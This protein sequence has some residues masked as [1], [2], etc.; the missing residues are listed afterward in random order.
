MMSKIYF[1]DFF[2]EL[3]TLAP[4]PE[5]GLEGFVAACKKILPFA[6]RARFDLVNTWDLFN[7]LSLEEIGAHF[8]EAPDCVRQYR[9]LQY[10]TRIIG[11]AVILNKGLLK[12]GVFPE[13]FLTGLVTSCRARQQRKTIRSDPRRLLQQNWPWKRA[14][15]GM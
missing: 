6:A 12:S 7:Y 13:E 2:G 10:V 3:K 1:A 5:E 11:T 14:V 9:L 15:F 4:D 8:G